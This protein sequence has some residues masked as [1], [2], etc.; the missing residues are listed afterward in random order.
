MK[1]IST[2]FILF[3]L[4]II[5]NC[6]KEEQTKKEFTFPY[7]FQ[8]YTQT[9]IFEVYNNEKLLSPNPFQPK[10]FDEF[11]NIID[12]IEKGEFIPEIT[13]KTNSII[14]VEGYPEN[15]YFFKENVLYVVNLNDTLAFGIGNYSSFKVFGNLTYYSKTD[16]LGNNSSISRFEFNSKENSLEQALETSEL[17]ALSEIKSLDTLALNCIIINYK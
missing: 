8:T 15:N 3:S 10:H 13:F 7:T 2:Y 4:L 1:T 17:T 11:K 6:K 12:S 14:N 5:S 16:G 9:G